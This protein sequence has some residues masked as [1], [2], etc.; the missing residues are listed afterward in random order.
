MAKGVVMALQL[1]EA[2]IP[3]LPVWENKGRFD[4]VSEDFA[5]QVPLGA[6]ASAAQEAIEAGWM[7]I[8]N[9]VITIQEIE[10][11]GEGGESGC[12]MVLEHRHP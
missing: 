9:K 8:A 4:K 1:L 3:A 5:Q 2:G 7:S 12:R 6:W 10:K 11:K